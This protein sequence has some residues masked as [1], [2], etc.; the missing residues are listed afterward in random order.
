MINLQGV[1][2]S[3]LIMGV[4]DVLVPSVEIELIGNL[5]ML[6]YTCTKTALLRGIG[7]DISWGDR[8]N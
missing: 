3:L 6:N 8:T 1:K 5:I 4:I 2:Q 7:M